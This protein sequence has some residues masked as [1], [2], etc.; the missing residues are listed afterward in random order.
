[1]Q[2][3]SRKQG[4]QSVK[5]GICD[6]CHRKKRE[7]KDHK[8]LGMSLY[9]SSSVN[10]PQMPLHSDNFRPLKLLLLCWK[11]FA[12]QPQFS[13][14][15]RFMCTN[16]YIPNSTYSGAF[17]IWWKHPS[18]TPSFSQQK[19]KKNTFEKNHRHILAW[20]TVRNDENKDIYP[21]CLQKT[22]ATL[23]Y[24]SII[25]EFLVRAQIDPL[26]E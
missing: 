2:A 15:A 17:T 18:L 23:L 10:H 20:T 9:F 1:M 7:K 4:P 24:G 22:E 12:E 21:N 8:I 26:R 13:R 5:V 14:I 3:T 25:I 6:R 11:H 19:R 16:R